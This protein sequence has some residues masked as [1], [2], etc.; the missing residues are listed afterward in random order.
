M[1]KNKIESTQEWLNID[2]ILENG[3]VKLKNNSYIKIILVNPINYNLKSEL[4][5]EA[6]LNSYK[7]FFKSI[8]FDFQI[9]IQSKKE[10]LSSNLKKLQENDLYQD[11]KEKY[12]KYIKE[13][14][15]SRKSS[16]KSFYIIIKEDS[17]EIGDNVKLQNLKTKYMKIKDLLSRCGN[18]V[19]EINKQETEELFY[20]ILNSN[21]F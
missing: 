17:N 2:E 15:K 12:I 20:S 19:F 21:K 16:S 7:N 10:D 18:L 9:L 6:I 1:E 11:I 14:N 4:E 13:L 5:K 3:M 8:N